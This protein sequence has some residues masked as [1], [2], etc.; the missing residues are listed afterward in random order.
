MI[1]AGFGSASAHIAKLGKLLNVVSIIGGL[2]LI[3]LGILL[4]TNKLGIWTAYFYQWFNFINYD[5]LLDY[6]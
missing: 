1:A 5:C 4:L 3:F 2:L 6:L